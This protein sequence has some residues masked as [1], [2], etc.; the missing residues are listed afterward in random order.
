MVSGEVIEVGDVF[1]AR[2]ES[3]LVDVDC[4]VI[5][6]ECNSSITLLL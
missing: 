3:T 6:A 4:L 2:V 5:P 1:E